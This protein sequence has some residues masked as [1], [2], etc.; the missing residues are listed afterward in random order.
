MFLRN[1]GD[2][3]TG[4]YTF[5]TN[6]F[7]IN[8]STNRVGIGTTS[9]AAALHVQGI[10][11]IN[12]GGGVPSG[13][14]SLNI[15][16]NGDQY[17]RLDSRNNAGNAGIKFNGAGY[18]GAIY[19]NA[20]YDIHIEPNA[21]YG[22][23]N[24]IINP[25][26]GSATGLGILD[27]T[28]DFGVESAATGTAG[29]FGLSSTAAA[30]GDILTVDMSGNL[31]IGSTTPSSR[32][33]VSGSAFFGGNLVATGTVQFTGITNGFLVADSSGTVTASST[34]SSSFIPDNYLLNTGDTATG[35]Y[36]FDSNT[37]VIDSVNNRIGVGTATPGSLFSMGTSLGLKLATYE[38]GS[39]RYGLGVQSNLFELVTPSSGADFTFGYGTSGSLTRLMTVMGSGNVGIGTSSP[40]QA[41]EIYG[42]NKAIKLTSASASAYSLTI[43]NNY[44]AANPFTLSGYLGA[45]N[46]TILDVNRDIDTSYNIQIGADSG[47][48]AQDQISF[49]TNLVNTMT[50]NTGNVG[51]GTTSPAAKL[52]VYGS[53]VQSWI[54]NT[55][56]SNI[57]NLVFKN[58]VGEDVQLFQGGSTYSSYGGA[59]SFNILQGANAP[60]VFFTNGSNERLRI[61]GSGYVGIGTSTV[62]SLL[63]L[64]EGT[65]A[66]GG[67]SFGADTNLYRNAANSLRT[68]DN[69]TV[70][71]DLR[72]NNVKDVTGG[73]FLLAY[74]SDDLYIGGSSA[75]AG[76]VDNVI[77]NNA[78]NVGIGTTTAGAKL[79][80]LGGNIRQVTGTTDGTAGF[81]LFDS[82]S[83]GNH[84][85]S[86]TRANNGGKIAAY[87]YLSFVTGATT[88]INT[89]TERIRITN[90]GNVGIGTVSPAQALEVVGRVQVS[91]ATGGAD[92]FTIQPFTDGYTYLNAFGAGAGEGGFKFR[93]NDGGDESVTITHTGNVGIGDSSPAAIFTVGNG[94]LFQVN[95]SGAIAAATGITS[96]GTITLS[97]LTNGLLYANG[98]GVL[99]A[100]STLSTSLIPDAYLLNTGDTATG[101]YNFSSGTLFIDDSAGRVGV[102]TTT[103]T[104]LLSVVGNSASPG[105][106]STNVQN[107]NVA[108][109]A[110]F[111]LQNNSTGKITIQATGGSYAIPTT[112][113][114]STQGN[115]TS[116]G[117]MTNGDVSSGGSAYI[118]FSTG[119]WASS[120]E[121]MRITSSGSV[122][123]GTTAP[124]TTN[125]GLDIASGGIGLILGADN[126]ASTRTNTTAKYGRLAFSHY[127]NAEEPFAGFVAGSDGS[128][129]TLSI[130]GGSGSLNS[131]NILAFYTGATT[132]TL[133]GTERM[134]ITATGNVGIGTTSPQ[135][136]LHLY[137]S[138]GTPN[139]LRIENSNGYGTLSVDDDKLIADAT[140]LQFDTQG[141]ERMRI[142]GTGNVGI[143]TT[144]PTALLHVAK[145]QVGASEIKLTN[146]NAAGFAAIYFNS[147]LAQTT[148][149]IL[150]WNNNTGS[151]NLFLATAGSSPLY[152]GTNNTV[153]MTV[154]PTTGNVGIGDSSPSA[155]LTVGNGDLF[156]VNSSGA[157]AA[158]TGIT[159]S[160]TITLS[161]L[162]NGLLYA[163]GSGV[164]S[165]TSTISSG[166]IED[167]YLLNTGDTATGDYNFDSNTFVI[168]SVNNNVG[169]GTTTPQTPL[170][171]VSSSIGS[172]L[173]LSTNMNTS[174]AFGLQFLNSFSST[175]PVAAAKIEAGIGSS[176]VDPFLAFSTAN[177]TTAGG[178]VSERMRITDNGNVGIGTASP[179][180]YLDVTGSFAS[181][182][183][184]L[185]LRSG[186]NSGAPADAYQIL[187]SYNGGVDYTHNIRS[188]HNSGAQTGNALDFYVWN[189]GVDGISTVGT[190][191][192]LTLEGTGNVGIGTTT[193]SY[194]LDVVGE[195]QQSGQFLRINNQYATIRN[196]YSG[197][198]SISL[199]NG[200]TNLA[201]FA[202]TYNSLY[203]NGTERVRIDN[204]G[205][206]GIGSTTP[207]SRLTVSGNAFFGGNLIATGTVQFTG[208]TDGFL[209]A[210]SSGNVT[211]SSTLSTSFIPDA[212]LLNT[213]DTATGDYNF[214]SDTFVIDSVNNRV[215]IGTGTPQTKLQVMG[216]AT[217][218]LPSST[219]KGAF[220]IS[221]TNTNGLSFGSISAAP[222]P[223]YIQSI[224]YRN[225]SSATYPLA[226]N[227]SGGNVG[228]GTTSPE[229]KLHVDGSGSQTIKI[230]SGNQSYVTTITNNISTSAGLVIANGTNYE[231]L[232]HGTGSGTKLNFENGTFDVQYR[233]A[234]KLTVNA[235]GNVGIGTTTPS[236]KLDV[237]SSGQAVVEIDG[238]T[239][240]SEVS[241]R[242]SGTEAWRA[243]YDFSNNWFF[244]RDQV[245][246][247]NP[248]VIKDTAS[249]NSLVIST[250]GNVGIGTTSPSSKLHIAGNTKIDGT[251]ST[252][253]RAN[254]ANGS[255]LVGSTLGIDENE[256]YFNAAAYIGTLGSN[257]LSIDTAGSTRIYITGAG[258]VGIG[259][260]SP[261]SLFTVGT[262]DAFQVNSSGAIAAATGITSSGTIT[263]SSLTNGL[264]YANGSGVLS[265]TSTL[266]TS[267]IP[268]AY[269]LNTGDTIT[270]NLVFGGSTANIA[271]GSNWL[272]GDGADEGLSVDSNG[273]VSASGYFSFPN[274]VATT[275]SA[276]LYKNGDEL[277]FKNR[278]IKSYVERVVEDV[279]VDPAD[280]NQYYELGQ[281]AHVSLEG[282][283]TID[284]LFQGSGGGMSSR[285]NLPVSWG[286][287]YLVDYGLSYTSNTWMTLTP[288]YQ[289][290]RHYMTNADDYELQFKVNGNTIQFRV[291]V[292]TPS[293]GA[294]ST[295]DLYAKFIHSNDYDGVTYTELFGTGTDT[296][297]YPVL[298][299]INGALVGETLFGNGIQVKGTGT[300]TFAGRV[301]IGTTTPTDTLTVVG[302]GSSRI[303]MG[304]P[305][306]SNFAA[307][308]LGGYDA[309][310]QG[311]YNILSGS[312]DRN[313]YLNR[314]TSYGI[315]F[316]ENN[317]TS[318][319]VL[320]S[321]GNVGIGT[322]TPG[323]KLTVA[324]TGLFT[325]LTTFT[326]GLTAS[327]TITLPSIT[328]GLLYANGSGVLSAT[329][330]I[331]SG[332]IEDAFLRNTGDTATGDYNF[333][334]GTLFIDDSAG[335]VGVGT[336]TPGTP[337][338]VVNSGTIN[339]SVIKIENPAAANAARFA[340]V[341][342]LGKGAY[343]NMYGSSFSVS[344]LAGKAGFGSDTGIRV[345]TDAASASGGSNDI[346]F[347][348]GGYDNVALT[349]KSTGNVGIG[350]TTPSS[351]L[352][353]YTSASGNTAHANYDDFVVETS[354]TGGMTLLTGASSYGA[355]LFGDS[356]SPD[357][358]GLTYNHAADTMGFKV[359]GGEKVT[360]LS[361]GNVGIG[362][363][364]P[365]SK[366]TVT[367]GD[368][369]I[370]RTSSAPAKIVLNNQ[371][372]A[373][374]EP[375]YIQ[376]G[377]SGYDLS[378]VSGR[379]NYGTISLKTTTSGSEQTRL[380]VTNA[381][382]VGIG[383]T[384]PSTKL[385]I[386]NDSNTSAFTVQ[387]DNNAENLWI[388]I[389]PNGTL[390]A[391][392]KSWLIGQ[393][394]N[395]DT[396]AFKAYDG[397]GFVDTM[398]F[399][400]SGNV[401]IGTTTPSARL[402][403]LTTSGSQARFAYDA[404]NYTDV[405]YTGFN[406]VGGSQTFSI[407]G[408]ERMRIDSTGNMG[409]GTTTPGAKLQVLG[410]TEQ[411]RL[412]Y[413]SSSYSSL[414]VSSAGKLT[415]AATGGQVLVPNGSVIAGNAP[416]L[417]F[418]SYADTGIAANGDNFGLW[419]SGTLALNL[420]NLIKE[421]RV[422]SDY[423]FAFSS[424]TNNN[425]ASDT[426]FYR[427]SAGVLR[428]G[429]SFIADGDV[430]IGTTTPSSKFTVI[431]DAFITGAL[432]DNSNSAGTNG[433][434]LQ[435]TGTGFNWVATSTLGISGGSSVWSTSGSDAYYTTGNV[436]IGTTS[437]SEKL[438]VYG[439]IR[440]DG[441]SSGLILNRSTDIGDAKVTFSTGGTDNWIA[442]LDNNPTTA[443][444]SF[445]IKQSNNGTPDF[446]I[447]T[448]G[449]V[450][451][452][453]TSPSQKL[454][455]AGSQ[456]SDLVSLIKNYGAGRASLKVDG[457]GTS[458]SNITF[459][460]QG[461]QTAKLS[462]FPSIPLVLYGASSEILRVTNADNVGIGTSTIVARLTV[463]TTG[464]TDIMNLF[465]TGGT[466]V[467]TVLESGNVGI[468]DTTPG[469]LLTVG[470]GD[471][472][473]V[474]SAGNVLMADAKS[475][476]WD[477]TTTLNGDTYLYSS[478]G[479]LAVVANSLEFRYGKTNSDYGTTGMMLSS[480]GNLG[481]GDSSPA[482]KLTVGNGD[483]FQVNASGAIAAATGITSSGTITLSSLTNGLLYAN[484]SGVLSST[485]TLSTS[486][487]PDAYLLNTGDTATGDYNFDSN[488][489]VIDSATDRVGIG[490][491]T[492][493]SKLHVVGAI[494]TTGTVNAWNFAAVSS[495]G[496][497]SG[498]WDSTGDMDL[499]LRDDGGNT[500]V[501]LRSDL[502][503]YINA[504]NFG[505]G[506]TTPSHK[507]TVT[508]DLNF[509]GAL[510]V[511]GNSGTAGMVLLSNGSS[512]PTWVA[513]STLGI[514]GGSSVWSTSGSNAYY[515]TGSVGIGTASPEKKFH[516]EQGDIASYSTGNTTLY[517]FGI[518]GRRARGTSGSPTVVQNGDLLGMFLGEGYDGANYQTAGGVMVFT[519][520]TP[521]SG[522]VPGRVA[523][524]TANSSGVNTERLT[525]LSNGN[526]GI[527]TT[528]PN[529]KLSVLDSS[530]QLALTHGSQL[531]SPFLVNVDSNAFVHF[532]GTS[533]F[534]FE[535]NSTEQ[536]RITSTGNVGIGTSSPNAK[537]DVAGSLRAET[538][539]SVRTGAYADLT[540][541]TYD[542]GSDFFNTFTFARS[543]GTE[544][545]PSTVAV[546][547]TLA[548]FNVR[549]HNGTQFEN[550][551]QIK[552]AVDNMNITGSG[553]HPAARIEFVVRGS[554]NTGQY[555]IT[556]TVAVIDSTGTLRPST[557][558]GSDLG[559]NGTAWDD[560]YYDDAFNQGSA[561][562]TDRSVAEEILLYPPVEKTPGMFD[563]M[564]ER[565][566]VEL[567]P[568]YL[569]PDLQQDF[570]III[571]EM[572]TYLY[573][574]TYEQ[575]LLI[576]SLR[577]Q[578]S[579][580]NNS[581]STA[582][583]SSNA[584]LTATAGGR[585][586]IGTTT[587][588]AQLH[589][590]GTVRLENYGSGTLQ[591]DVNGNLT[592]S[593]DERLKNVQGEFARGLDAIREIEPITYRWKSISGL[594]TVTEY[595]GFSA[596][597]I[598]GAIP[599]AVGED[600]RGYKT[601]SDRPI[602][603][604]VVNAV[605]EL[606]ERTGLLES[607]NNILSSEV[608][609]NS[610]GLITE[611]GDASE[612]WT[613]LIALAQ[614]FK[615][616]V[617]AIVG[618]EVEYVKADRVETEE[619]CVGAVCVDET[620]FLEMVQASG[621][622]YAMEPEEEETLGGNTSGGSSI[623]EDNTA[624]STSEV[625]EE[626]ETATSTSEVVPDEGIDEEGD[627]IIEEIETT[628]TEETVQPEEEPEQVPETP[629]EP[630]PEPSP[631]PAPE[632]GG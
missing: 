342:N 619:L 332:V 31:G 532:N 492:P 394:A 290:P 146:N 233:D 338:H 175:Y 482:A 628:Q 40:S 22:Q 539:K 295:L 553:N 194:A 25:I 110:R 193:P 198:G 597:N 462:S 272:S 135:D 375:A 404:N 455:V 558:K 74:S 564:T 504:G 129:N 552:F 131:A 27:T 522:I 202:P 465:E 48:T 542:N 132:A 415:I 196:T 356:G 279:S 73:D 587:P 379:N 23:A 386:V 49:Y 611:D 585:V 126:A 372:G 299:Y 459:A 418:A 424:A 510:R 168:D 184:A 408:T 456:G 626:E 160:G 474:T 56:A 176:G 322:T 613:R 138:L 554:G 431:G 545:S 147:G 541:E 29:Y 538:L 236:S 519:D 34:L 592:V 302:N 507:L 344:A 216:T 139:S 282:E 440:A 128:N 470:A 222:Y 612:F 260:T 271:L 111:S 199:Q 241:F 121:R 64:A 57:S 284:L 432:K 81:E 288:T 187:F 617:L 319:M 251:G 133:T 445:S 293:G 535:N 442:G 390:G 406:T 244:V 518:M 629:A 221:F 393:P 485:S 186:D 377:Y 137:S 45:A 231:V 369:L 467:F 164:L 531:A 189:Q 428:T 472:F 119:G 537:L 400:N 397:V 100:T 247:T 521:S 486:F 422:P 68:D 500:G 351:K 278:R 468:G 235:L 144:T 13:S 266:S 618:V 214:D 88:G 86:F 192:V 195:M 178:V 398:A 19:G 600:S 498:F 273:V 595:A 609:A 399:T 217:G 238:G 292:T 527:G 180:S 324:G 136:L 127:T 148:G 590:T 443:K 79:T 47:T 337:F 261:A 62:G 419:E 105:G 274:N 460:N 451:I 153:R 51:I 315:H 524:T 602:L 391:S 347:S 163:N 631:E 339:Q 447:N 508:G 568:D 234:S 3:A 130:G 46:Q 516:V 426:S 42:N 387:R 76:Q 454:E 610:D 583:S 115:L 264:L 438:E 566:L 323:T 385:H 520:G 203:T 99:S 300:S 506:T 232:T 601:L 509:T 91:N 413:D 116:L 157:I 38:N 481:I 358:A 58:D 83:G 367:D 230:S 172:L 608:A 546:N 488:T 493:S 333:S 353:V 580:F 145:D 158:A 80:V 201:V 314:P 9:P 309:L 512:A 298:P 318:Q 529:Y 152:L 331:S 301:G 277:Y 534:A 227:P 210:D 483:L 78:G 225:G 343:F 77:L 63:T 615:E 310:T 204:T 364:T 616:G 213:G 549:A 501:L 495:A 14:E 44:N 275:T 240:S 513:T 550:A 7:F 252:I 237:H 60:I 283:Y 296:A 458:D 499:Y 380:H 349:V 224:D 607:L 37:F 308:Q 457:G 190:K 395:T 150:Q 388:S 205:N 215:G 269:V 346:E 256:L 625:I 171:I 316:R 548:N 169:I 582:T 8:S 134:R 378:L 320:A 452:G 562:F 84:I 102:G 188:R 603:A 71:T 181:G 87:D 50:L 170:S 471:L 258:N 140:I 66:A 497:T 156:Q 410:T 370:D 469:S 362:T 494:R 12:N 373:N 141:T 123:I 572:V 581:Y 249:S 43:A 473:Q 89:G 487:I 555:N 477:G 209:V 407:G 307:I 594:E 622:A 604:A 28:P 420:S 303:A 361:S 248:F 65:T 239:T 167:A 161:S 461:T 185:R 336:T 490:T 544:A 151:N 340:A 441:T 294:A 557:H 505:I 253:G 304:N 401:G 392:N 540:V 179:D 591:T 574:G 97:S 396:L 21:Q 35:D 250:G 17:I 281:M 605:K 154:S 11:Y 563:Y 257:A 223:N 267:L 450:G 341:N 384:S 345:F 226:L 165:A 200:S 330:T 376:W 624:T 259:D 381:G 449:N 228:I 326:S 55:S 280:T 543:G 536:V 448:S 54:E 389:R 334:S 311:N 620:T 511:N 606:D 16:G 446:V 502:D 437:P 476:I 69:F 159:S 268:D 383:T 599:E 212:Y 569:P 255:L 414:T 496:N 374:Y 15:S 621:A 113:N 96:S 218:G 354:G 313:L 479:A 579:F 363:T 514:S 206:V 243:G 122:G 104:D 70:G 480:S 589:T 30:D 245:S 627:T 32:L 4:D 166:V 559:A 371:G 285:Y 327:G 211:A 173:T 352:H 382:N 263:L 623:E 434:V 124:G 596:Q 576:N 325:G 72:V 409:I 630:E 305:G 92:S 177:V 24:V 556:N 246:G 365:S 588:T 526:V 75:S 632:S 517:S 286:M 93:T 565:G 366:L 423:K 174:G 321:G 306:L 109:D 112:G 491:T 350:T 575:Q 475:L 242:E 182:T 98:S 466:E 464:T 478:A 229:T 220:Q 444:D 26:N 33:T 317:G 577:N 417:A 489:L 6:T 101:D 142:T 573:K 117:F 106:V 254:I 20:S 593:S 571:D 5:D 208:I 416:G 584:L 453:T 533:G 484:G 586:G 125:G 329:S 297:T 435:S 1:D 41:L 405:T 570:N 95:S 262:G 291:R 515:N 421:F 39:T 270:G 530:N 551:A 403:V 523:L 155:M 94:D 463:Q 425:S 276:F 90:A 355:Y 528:T 359:A 433:M 547:D 59:Q 162:T 107:T 67:I 207:S 427:N 312:T 114:I 103:P 614:S 503:S 412:G 18:R 143:G 197:G 578:T 287:D 328:S 357:R 598:N 439:N 560:L 567:N 436:G 118:T 335:R 429:G 53:G 411:L 85:L 265:A 191:H 368:L 10:T 183:K 52:H 360:V 561:A 289:A 61:T 402:H 525:V 149:G 108:G 36:N 120:N 348:A 82:P 2:T 430:G 219:E